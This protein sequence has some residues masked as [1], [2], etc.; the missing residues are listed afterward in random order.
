[1]RTCAR[2]VDL[3][4]HL[5]VHPRQQP[6]LRVVEP[7]QDGEERDVL[8]DHRLRLDLLHPAGEDAPRVGLDRHPRR[9]A[10]AD[11]ADVHLV[12]PRPR[13]HLGEVGHREHRGAARDVGG[14]RGDDLTRLDLAREDGAGDRRADGD[15]AQ[16]LAGERQVGLGAHHAGAR[17]RGGVGRLVELELGDDSL[18]A[19]PPHALELRLGD[20]RRDARGGE[21]G[22][23]LGVRVAHVARVDLGEERAGLHHGA[24]LHQHAPDLARGARL[25]LDHPHRLDQARRLGGDLEI[26]ALDRGAR[27]VRRDGARRAAAGRPPGDAREGGE[28]DGGEEAAG[29]G[30]GH[31]RSSPRHGVSKKRARAGK[32]DDS[33]AAKRSPCRGSRA[34]GAASLPGHWSAARGWLRSRTWNRP[35]SEA[36]RARSAW[37]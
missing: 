16:P 32:L 22:L 3:D 10:G 37:R 33:S 9:L 35:R 12:D 13:P 19:Q 28:T 36:G 26:A 15:V 2:P 34:D 6:A 5:G 29:R 25:H 31:A 11:A 30:A 8:L 24:A 1:M 23:G 21:V 18:L 17:R 20:A 27:G 4:R 7:H 14:R